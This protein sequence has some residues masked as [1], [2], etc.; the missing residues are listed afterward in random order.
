VSER[1]NLLSVV[2]GHG[3]TFDDLCHRGCR[4]AKSE[5][6]RAK[7]K[8]SERAREREKARERARK[9]ARERESERARE[10][11]S[12]RRRERAQGFSEENP[13]SVFCGHVRKREREKT[14]RRRSW[15][16]EKVC[17]FV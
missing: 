5:S 6:E 15:T 2:C 9:I 12:E 11:E 13:S 8:D 3:K 1:E 17:V 14:H 7:E 16:R 4:D 10:R